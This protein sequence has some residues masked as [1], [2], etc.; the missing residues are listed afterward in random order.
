MS[1]QRSDDELLLGR[2]DVS[3]FALSPEEVA[4]ARSILSKLVGSNSDL[5]PAT[6]SDR[7]EQTALDLARSVHFARK[8]RVEHFG[9]TLFSEPAWD[10]LLI[11]FIYGDRDGERLSVTR[12]AEYGD[13]PL[14]T[15]IRWLDYLESQRMIIRQQS[16]SDRRKYMVE[17]SDRGRTMLVDYFESLLSLR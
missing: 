17:L 11:L 13:A 1:Y 4:L 10:M 8:R 2:E 16:G 3:V 7:R 5:D 15:A 14:T 9:P 6:R 12:L